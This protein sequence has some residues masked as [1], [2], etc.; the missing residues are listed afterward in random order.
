M[1]VVYMYAHLSDVMYST[2]EMTLARDRFHLLEFE[3]GMQIVSDNWIQKDTN[4]CWYPNYITDK[5]INKAIKKRYIPED[6]WLS[7]P[8]KRL[9]GIL[10]YGK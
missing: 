4:K 5:D 6:G 8:I 7:Y 1:Y 2:C 9:F 3:D 10:V